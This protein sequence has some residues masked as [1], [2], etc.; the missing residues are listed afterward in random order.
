MMIIIV[1]LFVVLILLLLL[2]MLL[3]LLLL[4]LM[5]II[6]IVSGFA[7]TF[8]HVYLNSNLRIWQQT[9]STMLYIS[10]LVP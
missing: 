10:F 4:L 3:L 2:L 7:V 5:M 9:R 6:M 1:V 8:P